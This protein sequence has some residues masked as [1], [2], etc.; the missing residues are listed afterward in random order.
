MLPFHNFW[1]GQGGLVARGI[2]WQESNFVD[3]TCHASYDACFSPSV[4]GPQP[5]SNHKQLLWAPVPGRLFYEACASL[6]CQPFSKVRSQ[7]CDEVQHK[8]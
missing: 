5:N 1:L 2:W 6:D 8:E 3:R 4:A 7:V